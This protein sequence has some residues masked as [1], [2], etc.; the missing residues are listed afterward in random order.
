MPRVTNP[1]ERQHIANLAKYGRLIDEIFRAATRE[2]AAIGSTVTDFDPSRV[3]SFDDYPITHERVRTLL[4]RLQSGVETAIVNGVEAE[5]TLANNKC[6]ALSQL[7]FGNN[8]GRLT[9]AQ[10][11]RYFSSNDDARQAFLAR[12]E[13]G[14]NLSERVWRYANDFR[15]D[16][17]LGLDVGI[18]S[19]LDADA[20]SRELRTFLQQ[21]ER[22]FRRVRDEH[23]NLVLSQRASEYHPGQGV[24]RSS[25][26]NA[27]RLAV[28]ETN[29]AYRTAEYDRIQGLD[30][31]VGIEIRLSN[32]HTCN[33]VPLTDICDDLKGRYPKDFKFTGWHPHCRCHVVTILKTEAELMEENAAI[34]AGEEP[35]H[36]SVNAVNEVPDNFKQWIEGNASRIVKA[37]SIPY[38]MKDN[39]GVVARVFTENQPSTN[40]SQ[41]LESTVAQ[42]F[43]AMKDRDPRL[44]AI[45]Q[46]LLSEEY[47]QMT[48]IE[49]T[50]LLNQYRRVSG[51]LTYAD[52]REWGVIDENIVMARIDSAYEVQKGSVEYVNGKRIEIPS[53]K[54]DMLVLKDQYGME[55][56]YP[57]GVTRENVLFNATEASEVVQEI[58]LFVR[59]NIRRVSFYPM[60]SPLEDYWRAKYNRPSLR[61]A[62]TDGSH[63]SF[64]E[65]TN[66]M[67]RDDFKK[68]I[69]HEAGH[70]LDNAKRRRGISDSAGW[71]AA[72][73]A[74]IQL[75]LEKRGKILDYPT[76][77][78]STDACEDLAE[79]IMLFIIDRAR[80]KETALNRERFLHELSIRLNRRR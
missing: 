4:S 17:E 9:Q 13:Q 46:R 61:A 45:S 41:M 44:A 62:A 38:F 53:V 60:E 51:E 63:V 78:A 80:L 18:R 43:S 49:R 68:Y 55:F 75:W 16:I 25:Y 79:S 19:G 28:T 8:I 76:D 72:E 35:S 23:G 50:A 57:V 6:S 77:Y 58:P 64:W 47:Y 30:F 69:C 15:K 71:R 56:A 27:R 12:K 39:I 40:M 70:A 54:R 3:F 11:R 42:Y 5:W 24:Y 31:V 74:D 73:K 66:G 29:M 48:D 7:V 26:K 59:R 21:P 22:L 37:R 36:D 2:A 52:L 20:M 32:N 65:C 67:S 1:Y 14:L 33:G 10:Y 34:L